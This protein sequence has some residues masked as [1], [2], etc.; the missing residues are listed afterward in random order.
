VTDGL[1]PPAPFGVNDD[2]IPTN[3]KSLGTRYVAR[4]NVH[5]A[6][7]ERIRTDATHVRLLLAGTADEHKEKCAIC[8]RCR[9]NLVSCPHRD[10]RHDGSKDKSES[11]K[12]AKRLDDRFTVVG[13][14]ESIYRHK[15]KYE[16]DKDHYRY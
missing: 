5:V 4:I 9:K 16:Q 2:E 3:L 6:T 11:G 12:D 7:F 10:R 8:S 15:R 1:P 13:M 14:G